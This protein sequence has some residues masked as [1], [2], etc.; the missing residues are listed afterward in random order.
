MDQS[1]NGIRS[2][3]KSLRRRQIIQS[4][5]RAKKFTNEQL[6]EQGFQLI[7]FAMKGFDDLED[8]NN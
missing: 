4:A 3:I 2:E 8:G 5:L 1:K 6:L 7:E